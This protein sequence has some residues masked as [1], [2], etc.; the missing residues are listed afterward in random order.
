MYVVK[1]CYYYFF[2]SLYLYHVTT[3]AYYDKM[4]IFFQLQKEFFLMNGELNSDIISKNW[5]EMLLKLNEVFKTRGVC[6]TLKEMVRNYD[7]DL[8]CASYFQ[9]WWFTYFMLNDQLITIIGNLNK[10]LTRFGNAFARYCTLNTK[11]ST[12]K[13]IHRVNVNRSSKLI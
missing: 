13:L 10:I 2:F 4:S 7:G 1:F 12:L 11:F 9:F 5:T 3:L 6:I 8:L